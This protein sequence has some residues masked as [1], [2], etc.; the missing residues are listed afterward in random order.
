[1]DWLATHC[2][3]S[4]QH[5][6]SVM[7]KGAVWLE[8]N[9]SVQRIR[10]ARKAL[11]V[12]DKLY[13]YYDAN[14]LAQQA[15]AATLMADYHDYSIWFKPSGML[16]HGS[17]WGDHCAIDRWVEQ[18]HER[19]PSCFLV[20]RLDRA[21]S[22]IILLAHHKKSAAALSHLFEQR[23][24]HKRYQ[25]LVAGAFPSHIQH[26]DTDIDGKSASTRIENSSYN[27]DTQQTLLTIKIDT[28]RK[29]Q[30]RKH[31]AH[32]GFAIIGDRLYHKEP[33]RHTDTVDLQLRAYQLDF[34]CPLSGEVRTMR[35][36][37]NQCLG[38]FRNL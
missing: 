24:I 27:A 13:L 11:L 6:K 25:A 38:F 14:V 3:L 12:G 30:I 19:Q 1:M 16:S 7:T 2:E 36:A 31:L 5:L 17:K 23:K 21:A 37:P 18:H 15:P 8:R 4:K 26:I 28:G 29:H 35:L 34:C 22:G 9:G 33:N 20:H 32:I 10:R